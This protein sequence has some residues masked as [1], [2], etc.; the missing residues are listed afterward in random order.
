MRFVRVYWAV[1]LISLSCWV[2]PA[3]GELIRVACVGDS[4]T[5]G[6]AL[7]DRATEA[8]PVRLAQLLGTN[9]QVHN[10]GVNATTLLV[11]G[12][13]PYIRTAAY[14]NALALN[15]DVVVIN[16]GTNDSKHRG[17][18]MPESEKAIDNWRYGT[19]YVRDYKA[20]IA[21]FRAAAPAATIYVCLPTPTYPGRW[22]INGRTIRDEIIPMIRQVAKETRVEIIDL[23]G[24][25]SGK[26]ELFP[27]KIHPNHEGMELMAAVVG[28]AVLGGNSAGP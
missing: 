25:L 15:P 12:D 9:Y 10:F 1:A 4:I 13:R 5:Y 28:Q 24:A 27:D 3:G 22:G 23:H 21:A 14:T 6:A 2:L 20:L 18:G 7:R 17:D 26:P 11:D 8:Y 19:N 16:L